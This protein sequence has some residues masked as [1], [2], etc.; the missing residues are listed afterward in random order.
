FEVVTIVALRYFVAQKCDLVIWETGMGGRLDATN[1]VTPLASVMTN[2][3]LDHQ[4]WLGDTIEKIAVEKAG[5]IKAG[6]PVLTAADEPSVLTVI[7]ETARS[8]NAPLTIVG[9][10]PRLK[11]AGMA[12]LSLLGEHQKIN[13]ALALAT[14]DS[15]QKQIPVAAEKIREGL[16]TI[17]WPGRLQL[18][19]TSTRQRILLDGA[20]NVAGAQV[21]RKALEEYFPVVQRTLILGVLQDKDW[22]RICET[23]APPATRILLVPVQSE[24]TANAGELAVACSVANPSAKVA[25]CASLGEAL[26]EAATDNFVVIAGSLYLVG[27]AL[28]KLDLSTADVGERGLNEWHAP[29]QPAAVCVAP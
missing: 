2:V 10:G 18:I 27:E 29:A 7:E 12:A 17:N 11:A 22:R 13:A 21:L 1:I 4:P 14:V 20:H 5:I 19:E 9:Q 24:R 26:E 3:Q 16:A 28:Q 6:V 23:L 25:A 8:H 15:L